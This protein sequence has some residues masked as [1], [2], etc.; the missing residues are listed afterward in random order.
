MT[1]KRQ[2]VSSRAGL[3]GKLLPV[4]GIVTEAGHQTR[5]MAFYLIKDTKTKNKNKISKNI[6]N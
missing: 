1:L 4:N 2:E 5:T 3:F 6:L